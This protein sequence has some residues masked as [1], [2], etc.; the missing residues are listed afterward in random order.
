[1]PTRR[2]STAPDLPK[3]FLMELED[4]RTLE[5]GSEFR[6]KGEGR[7]LFLSHWLPDGS[8]TAWGPVNSQTA[9]VRSFRPEQ[10][11]EIHR[12]KLNRKA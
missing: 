4:G 5:Q 6:V 8:V 11:A 10:V 3:R 2:K 1:M 12:K 9:Q 7:F